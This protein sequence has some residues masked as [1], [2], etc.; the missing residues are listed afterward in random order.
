MNYIFYNSI[1]YVIIIKQ[2]LFSI[3]KFANIVRMTLLIFI[4]YLF[5]EWTLDTS[6]IVEWPCFYLVQI[7]HS[8]LILIILRTSICLYDSFQI[9][10]FFPWLLYCC[11]C[12]RV[13]E[14]WKS[15]FFIRIPPCYNIIVT[16]P[17]KV[18]ITSIII[19]T[20]YVK[21]VNVLWLLFLL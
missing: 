20:L 21:C 16:F 10:V 15:R 17:E 8:N 7:R 18:L 2:L 9:T 19:I 11:N 3:I 14:N 13:L 1:G 12:F 6:Y 5:Q 4:M